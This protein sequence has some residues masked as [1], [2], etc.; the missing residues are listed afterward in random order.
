[1]DRDLETAKTL[2]LIAIIFD[3]IGLVF[4]LVFLPLA[5]VPFIFML[6]NYFLV[7][8]PLSEGHGQEAETS[9]LVLGIL[10]IIPFIGGV[11]PGL[12]LIFTWVKIRDSINRGSRS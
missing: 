9:A 6:L 5:I 2:A 11:I 10:Q 8:K 7:Y 1:M 3:L 4:A 12:L